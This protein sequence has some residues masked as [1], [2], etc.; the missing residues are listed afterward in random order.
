MD[1]NKIYNKFGDDYKANDLTFLMGIDIRFTNH[2]ASRFKNKIVLE[3]CSGG[4]F[5][6]ISLAKYAKHVYTVEIDSSRF[7]D[8]KQN[9]KIA[10]VE[11]KITFI[12]SDIF[13]ISFSQLNDKIDAALLDPD[14]AV[15]R[16]DH[17]Y[18]FLDSN[19]CPPSDRL[20]SF[21]FQYTPNISLIQ[22]PYIQES[23][24]RGLPNHECEKLF[25][26]GKHELYCLHFGEQALTVGNTEFYI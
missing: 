5:T 6:T 26:H 20:L 19:T 13:D 24:F 15:S 18:R 9:A 12:N 10:Q 1:R 17:Q 16:K 2:L 11:D 14:W 4:G 23:E 8:A 7:L 25:L 21:I 3:T 22:P